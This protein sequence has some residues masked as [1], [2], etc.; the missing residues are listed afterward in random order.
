MGD[1]YHH[2]TAITGIL[3]CY[4][5][6]IGVH[7]EAGE[8][9]KTITNFRFLQRPVSRWLCSGA[10]HRVDWYESVDV[11][12]VPAASIMREMSTLTMRQ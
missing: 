6:I 10:P 9:S 5:A 7:S 8:T 3:T 1:Y 2:I 4:Y 12:E 11:S